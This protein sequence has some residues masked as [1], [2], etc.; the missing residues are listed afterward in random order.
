MELD[1]WLQTD[2]QKDIWKY[3]YRFEEETLD[4]FFNRV[5]DSTVKAEIK[6]MM[7]DKKFLAGGRILANKGLQKKGKRVTFS[8]CYVIQPPEDNLESIFDAGKK[9]ART[10][11]LGG[12]CGIDIDKLA[13]RDA[14][15]NNAAKNSSG[16]VS[17]MDLYSLITG[18]IAQKGRR[19]ALMIS[20]G[21]KHPDLLEFIDLKSDLNKVTKAN[22]SIRLTNE[23]MKAA[24]ENKEWKLEFFREETTEKIEKVVNARELLK[25][26]AYMN[27]DYAEPGALFWD[28]IN[29]WTLLS[30]DEEFEFAGVNPCFTGNMKLLT[31]EGYKTF[32][33]LDDQKVNV[34]NKDGVIT[35]G[36]VWCSGEKEV[37]KIR[38]GNGKE[39]TCTPNHVF[40]TNDGNEIEAQDLKGKRIM[41]F[42]N[43]SD[44]F[45]L[46][47]SLMGFIQGDGQLSRLNSE[48][49][50]GI[51]VN[52]GQDDLEIRHLFRQNY[53]ITEYS[54]D[55]TIYVNGL[56]NELINLG[57]DANILPERVLPSTYPYW[58]LRQK[59]SFLR[60]CYSANGSVLFAGRVTYKTTC[61]TFAEQ[62]VETLDKDFNIK[63]YYTTNKP[64]DVTFG[65]GTYTCKESYDVNIANF[66]GMSKFYNEIG[67]IHRYKMFKLHDVLIQKAPKVTNVIRLNK[68][69]KVYDFTEPMTHWGVVE[70]VIVHNCAEEPL[71]AGGSCLLGSHNLSAYVKKPFTDEAYFDF[72]EFENDVK[73]TITY[74]NDVLD[75]GLPLHPIEEQRESVKNWRQTG[76]GLMA[77]AEMFI[78]LGVRYG[79]PESLDLVDKIGYLMINAA[80]QQSAILAKEFGT[81]PKYKKSVM[82][83]PFFKENANEETKKLVEKYG[84]RNS[85]LLTIAP[86]GSLSTMLGV[87][88]GVEPIFMLSYFRKTESLHNEEKT[89]KVYTPIVE[90]YMKI[91][92]IEN[93]ED[94]PNIFVTAMILDHR[95]RIDIQSIWQ[96]YIDASIS[97]TVNVNENFT[98]EEV[99]D[100]Y[101]YAWEKGLKGVTI[102]RNGCKRAGILTSDGGKEKE[103]PKDTQ[104]PK[105]PQRLIGFTEK[106]KFPL[107][108]KVGKAYITINVD[109]NNQPY[110][111]FIEANDIEIKSMAEKIGRLA[112]Q[113]LRYGNTRDNLEQVVKHLRKG[114]NM[115]SLPSIV[116]RLLEQIAVGKIQIAHTTTQE[117]K[118]PMLAE[119]PECHEHT[120]NRAECVCHNCGYS[121]CN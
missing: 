36:K 39:I 35:E 62:L 110:E 81:Y 64:K 109:E 22:I 34:V 105:R 45:D 12:G 92:G 98:I 24:K 107:G 46:E 3:K 115:N 31:S 75:E 44:D 28:R 27:W 69:E 121:K 14:L 100:L 80:M 65:N 120:F 56:N 67:F 38:F 15:V 50:R 91:K 93:E 117:N 19:G 78:K 51:E 60:G 102:F 37:V 7:I 11:S 76:L 119:C 30:N 101:L 74:L 95:E 8:N 87:S 68:T 112:T 16:A 53:H 90:E 40:M 63:A 55:R 5:A 49:H 59:R 54:N 47:Y 111:I 108:D 26:L 71:P 32:S 43:E 96:R 82:E 103:K 4:E 42:L 20:I 113:F 79:S 97:S 114:E 104:P 61:K 66:E 17:F 13:P 118:Q 89:Y 6:Q 86:T 9:L 116:A 18:L 72:K 23:F 77:K 2:L 1:N 84:L 58:D 73:T 70:G 85:Q 57:F 10:Y 21:D 29:D 106:V 25:K 99:E 33:E 41:P 52:V 94:L 88:G 83:T 48:Q